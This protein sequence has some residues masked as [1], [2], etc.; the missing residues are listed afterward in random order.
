MENERLRIDKYLWC[1]RI[2]KTR[3][4]AAEACLKGKVKHNGTSV[5]AAKPVSVGDQ[6][7][8]KTDNKKWVIRVTG[9]LHSRVD[10]QK[11]L[12]FYID[13]TPELPKPEKQPSSFI[14]FTGKRKSK[15]GR[16]TKKERRNL[17]DFLE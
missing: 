2:F 17:E 13:E 14:Y 8:I 4:L 6:Y 9:I 10:Y 12:Q 15:Q 3:S 16:P 7:E 5:K 1:I 11:S